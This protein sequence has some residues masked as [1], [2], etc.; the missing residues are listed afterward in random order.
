VTGARL[1]TKKDR[2]C[3]RSQNLELKLSERCRYCFGGVLAG[4]LGAG[5]AGLL[6]GDVAGLAGL[7]ATLPAAGAATPD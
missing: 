4:A 1:S 6:A 2:V 3:T 7:G 5:A